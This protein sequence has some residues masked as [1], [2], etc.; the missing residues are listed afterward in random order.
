MRF[1]DGEKID[2]GFAQGGDDIVPQQ[3]LGR[4]IEQLERAVVE[5]A[6]HPAALVG[7]GGGIE[8]RRLDPQLA[9]LRDLVAHERNQR[10]YHQGQAAPDD[11]RKLEAQRLAA[12]SWHD[13]QHVLA[14][15]RGAEDVLLARPEIGKTKDGRESRPRL[16]H[17][18][19]IGRHEP[20]RPGSKTGVHCTA[21]TLSAP[22]ASMMR[23]SNP[24]AAPLASGISASA[25]RKSSSIGADIP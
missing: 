3:P 25:R 2:R 11:R 15:E 5:A 4:D 24:S 21:S 6:G 13:R 9:Q 1:V 8:A 7:V 17:E 22:V 18:R 16:R 14:C 23:R 19:R 12:A 20:G 10:R